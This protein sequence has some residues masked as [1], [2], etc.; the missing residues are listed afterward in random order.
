MNKNWKIPIHM[1]MEIFIP[2]L[3]QLGGLCDWKGGRGKYLQWREML[4]WWLRPPAAAAAAAAAFPGHLLAEQMLR[5]SS[6][7]LRRDPL[8]LGPSFGCPHELAT[9]GS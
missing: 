2:F 5:P 4:P 9:Q 8:G 1:G 6:K 3:V 7:P